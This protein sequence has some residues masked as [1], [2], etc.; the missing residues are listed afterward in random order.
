VVCAIAAFALLSVAACS[1]SVAPTN[2]L[3]VRIDPLT[4][5]VF[6]GDV[7]QL[8]ARVLDRA[9]QE[10]DGAA[11]TWTVSDTNLAQIGTDGTLTLLRPGAVRVSAQS[12]GATV[13][14]D[15]VI[16][17]LVVRQV[18]TTP[19][20]FGLGR[21]D[22]VQMGVRLLGQGGR[23]ILGRSL[24]Y[25]ADDPS[26]A[27][28]STLGM[29]RAIGPGATVIRASIDG[30][31]AVVPVSVV[32]ADTTLTLTRFNESPVPALLV[33]DSIITNGVVDYFETYIDSGRFVL[34]GL[35]QLHYLV[36]VNYSVYR[37][38]TSGTDVHREFLNRGS[39]TDHGLAV[40]KADGG[41]AMESEH[42]S[43]LNHTAAPL[44]DGYQLH[45][46]LPGDDLASAWDLTFR[47][48]LP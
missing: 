23:E 4:D 22:V 3:T 33:S 43:P 9:G 26:V 16:G 5:S 28:V 12:G 1:D 41:L 37:V 7:V 18:E 21:G 24:V 14:Y 13:P 42:V 6:E 2:A 29:I 15:L 11:V 47:R 8:H 39:V 48:D 38:V 19:A 34:S 32:V 40:V 25:T 44:P 36:E 35:A 27:T 30:V 17:R 45:F 46:N 20:T 10:V 31:T